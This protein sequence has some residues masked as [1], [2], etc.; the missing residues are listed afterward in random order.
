MEYSRALYQNQLKVHKSRTPFPLWRCVCRALNVKDLTQCFRFNHNVVF[1]SVWAVCHSPSLHPPQKPPPSFT[2]PCFLDDD[3]IFA[4]LILDFVILVLMLFSLSNREKRKS[5]QTFHIKII[6]FMYV[7]WDE[8]QLE[9]GIFRGRKNF[10]SAHISF[11]LLLSPR[12]LSLPFEWIN[13]YQH[14]APFRIKEKSRVQSLK[15][16]PVLC[17]IKSKFVFLRASRIFLCFKNDNRMD[18]FRTLSNIWAEL[19]FLMKF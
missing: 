19:I 8:E 5:S 4:L 18:L 1:H 2:L 3:E 12:K 7:E 10:F 16:P 17:V 11:R 14:C 6:L 15:H 13:F 9:G